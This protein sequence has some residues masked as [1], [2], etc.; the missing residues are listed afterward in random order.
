MT[1]VRQTKLQISKTFIEKFENQLSHSDIQES[2]I[3]T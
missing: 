1:N 2:P 3:P